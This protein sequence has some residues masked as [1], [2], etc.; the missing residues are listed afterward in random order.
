M[1]IITSSPPPWEARLARALTR[2]LDGLPPAVPRSLLFS[3]GVDSGLLAWELR[4]DPDVTLST[5]GLEGSEDLA[6]AEKAALELQL[7][8]VRIAL[9]DEE[10]LAMARRIDAETRSLSPTARSVE[11]A[12]ALAVHRAPPGLVLCG[13]GADELFYGYAHFQGLDDEAARHRGEADLHYL[14]TDAWPRT[15]RV[16]ATMGREIVAPYLDPGFL[17]VV[18]EIPLSDRRASPVP[19]EAFR[20]FA[21]RR[22]LPVSIADRPKKALQ[23]GTGV[24]RLLRRSG[25]RVG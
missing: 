9:S 18:E 15:Q 22:G 14:L 23:Y 21:R 7:P 24:D 19:K 25:A 13:Q 6:A 3:G 17:S 11:V 8:W 16:A 4:R 5:V 12:L 10:V 2:A 20:S 1:S